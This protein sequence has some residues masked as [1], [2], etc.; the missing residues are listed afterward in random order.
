[1]KR[2]GLKNNLA[3]TADHTKLRRE[4]VVSLSRQFRAILEDLGKR[5]RTASGVCV[6][7]SPR[8]SASLGNVTIMNALAAL[9]LSLTR[10]VRPIKTTVHGFRSTA[11]TLLHEA[12]SLN[13][14]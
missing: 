3:G 2:K 10:D 4:H 5:T 11:S 14:W 1:M 7:P 12:G 13:I 9:Q 6:F 8:I